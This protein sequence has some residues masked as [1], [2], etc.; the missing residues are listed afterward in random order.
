MSTD[1]MRY[2]TSFDKFDGG[3]P[4]R[5]SAVTTVPLGACNLRATERKQCGAEGN[6][7]SSA[8]PPTP[9]S[10]SSD[11]EASRVGR[12]FAILMNKKIPNRQAL[13]HCAAIDRE[14][15]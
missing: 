8:L 15:Q 2:R 9:P 12:K 14:G 4:R 13:M 11:R 7:P 1:W 6:N 10:H 3:E 5:I